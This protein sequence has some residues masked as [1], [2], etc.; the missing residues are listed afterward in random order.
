LQ[1]F[2]VPNPYAGP[3]IDAHHHLWDLSLGRHPWLS[4]AAAIPLGD[5]AYMQHNYLIADYLQDIAGQG[6]TASVHI[7]ALWDRARSPVEETEWLETLARPSGIAARYV[8]AAPLDEPDI[9]ATLDAQAAFPRVTAIRETIRWHPD[10]KKRWTRAGLVN[11]AGW[12]RGLARL[13][14]H[15][16]ALDLLMNPHQANEVAALAADFPNQPILVNHCGTPND[17]DPEG[18]ARWRAGLHTMAAHPNI[19]IKLSNYGAYT[20]DGTLAGHRDTILTCIDAFGPNRCM[21]GSDYPVARRTMTYPALCTRFREIV[22]DFSPSEQRAL[23]HDTAAR[24][25]RF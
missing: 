8:A 15:N 12:R 14:Q 9:D 21:F 5:I 18:L 6:I 7:E 23:F 25:C 24:V 4:G 19:A 16:L 3:I 1:E 20:P 17:R 13:A 11:E 2:H 22:A 10:P